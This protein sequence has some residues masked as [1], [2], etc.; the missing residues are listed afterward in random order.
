MLVIR[1][2][3][4]NADLDHLRLPAWPPGS[5]RCSGPVATTDPRRQTPVPGRFRVAEAPGERAEWRALMFVRIAEARTSMFADPIS[6]LVQQGSCAEEARFAKLV[7]DL[8]GPVACLVIG[9][10]TA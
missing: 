5:K 2:Q 4:A 9:Q 3:L 8:P 6:L 10:E 7:D 1:R